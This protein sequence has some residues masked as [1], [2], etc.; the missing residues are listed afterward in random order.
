MLLWSCDTRVQVALLFQ[1]GAT[2]IDLCAGNGWIQ[3]LPAGA[4]QSHGGAP[5]N[6]STLVNSQPAGKEATPATAQKLPE[7]SLA[8]CKSMGTL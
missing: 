8:S 5:I 6:V 7:V 3:G 2:K 4:P 1:M